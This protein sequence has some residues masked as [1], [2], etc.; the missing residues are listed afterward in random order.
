MLGNSIY[1]F[2]ATVLGYGIRIL[3]PIALV[4]ILSKQDFGTYNQFFLLEVMIQTVFQMGVIQSLY[5]FVPRDRENAG[6]YLVNSLSLNIAI[7]SVAY[8]GIWFFKAQIA[9][10]LG[11]AIIFEY[12]WHLF[13]YTLLVMLNIGLESYCAARQDIK[14]ASILTIQREVVATLAT[15]AAAVHF[16]SLSAVFL[17]LIG[18]RAVTLLIGLAYVHFRLHGLRS[19]R[20]FFGLREQVRYGVVLGLGGSVGVIALRMHEMAVSRSYDLETYAVYA[21]G[22][23]QIPVIQ[24]FS[25]SVAAVALGQFAMLV[26]QDDW[27]GVRRLWERVLAAMYGVGLPVVALLVAFA[28]PLIRLM[29]TSEYAQATPIF[30]IN[31]LGTLVLVVNSTLVLRAM[32]RNDVTLKMNLAMCTV[33]LPALYLGREWGGLEGIISAHTVIVLAGMVGSKLY[34][35]RLAP[36]RLRLVPLPLDVVVFYRSVWERA[37]DLLRSVRRRLRRC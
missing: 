26:K 9:A 27:D 37:R 21:A 36:V 20:Y 28:D 22:L 5:Y 23:K 8:V 35:S 32:N 16:R 3:L 30:R 29:F 10:E 18:G 13:A 1:L 17:A 7:Y 4:R 6:G 2:L 31:C 11:M 15:L 19:R 25:Q 12:F 24:F 34:L 14:A 33:L